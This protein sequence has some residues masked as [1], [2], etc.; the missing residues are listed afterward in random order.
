MTR[1]TARPSAPPAV[2]DF[3]RE[4]GPITDPGERA[5]LLDGLPADVHSLMAVVGGLML[6]ELAGRRIYGLDRIEEVS[7]DASRFMADL[8][9]TIHALDPAPLAVPREPAARVYTDCRN[10]PLLLVTMLRQQGVPARK[11]TGYARYIAA[12]APMG[13]PHDLTEYWDE[14]RDRWVLVD[15]GL[16]ER[17]AA[18]WRAYHAKR[19][20]AWRGELDVRDVDR[21]LFLTG[22]EVWLGYRSGRIA[23]GQLSVA[24]ADLHRAAQ[25]LLED[26][27]SLNKTELHGHDLDVDRTADE[28]PGFLDRMAELTATVDERFDEMRRRFD[29][30]PWGRTARERLAAF[31][32]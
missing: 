13:M 25:V 14:E 12:A 27:D 29:A 31:A 4:H 21:G 9:A 16:D 18:R 10:P 8:L 30:S 32:R 28:A 20:E 23:T 22:P 3:Y 11:R 15:P 6:H 7:P 24:G 1:V 19:G 26:L 17:V 5:R 2:L